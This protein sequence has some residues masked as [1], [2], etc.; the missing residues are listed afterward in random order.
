M[1]DES[2]ELDEDS[3]SFQST[4]FFDL[5]DEVEVS[6]DDEAP[7]SEFRLV[8]LA[9][10]RSNGRRIVIDETSA[11]GGVDAGMASET[12][13]VSAGLASSLTN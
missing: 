11:A 5:A 9:G 10:R 7:L 4:V 6:D 3:S 8:P 13:A 1:D 2:E 12:V